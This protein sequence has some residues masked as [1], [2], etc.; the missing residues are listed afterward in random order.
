MHDLKVNISSTIMASTLITCNYEKLK[1]HYE[2]LVLI[3]RTNIETNKI[4]NA[5]ALWKC[6]LQLMEG[7]IQSP[8]SIPEK[9]EKKSFL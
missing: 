8:R 3:T 2:E 1:L 9:K 7:K 6:Q 5:E 4:W